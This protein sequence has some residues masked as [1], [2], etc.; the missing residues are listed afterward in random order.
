MSRIELA[1]L[2]TEELYNFLNEVKTVHQTKTR[3]FL[4]FKCDVSE[5]KLDEAYIS[6]TLN[7]EIQFVASFTSE[8]TTFPFQTRFFIGEVSGARSKALSDIIDI[9]LLVSLYAD[10]KISDNVV[11][12]EIYKLIS[13]QRFPKILVT[14]AVSEI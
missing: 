7:N 9:R 10:N 12:D 13:S 1:D 6:K 11:I 5:F 4:G 3:K 8:S 2:K 14:Q